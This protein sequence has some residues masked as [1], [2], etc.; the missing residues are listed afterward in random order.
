MVTLQMK[1]FELVSSLHKLENP[2]NNARTMPATVMKEN[3]N[4]N[5][6]QNE[7]FD[8]DLNLNKSEVQLKTTEE[9][10]N[11]ERRCETEVDENIKKENSTESRISIPKNEPPK[12]TFDP[13]KIKRGIVI[14]PKRIFL[15]TR[16]AYG[17]GKIALPIEQLKFAESPREVEK[18]LGNIDENRKTYSGT[19]TNFFK[20]D[21]ESIMKQKSISPNMPSK[22]LQE[23]L[24]SKGI[25]IPQ[26]FNSN[27]I[28]P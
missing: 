4:K 7:D 15:T 27:Q 5:D 16:N 21:A 6:I 19:W 18:P 1:N 11:P 25:N 3:H 10:Q 12:I 9:I 24:L 17:T 14:N 8:N 23:S 20:N 13:S 2:T 28:N 26:L 22:E